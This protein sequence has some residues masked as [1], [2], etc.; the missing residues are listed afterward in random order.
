[1]TRNTP[2][3]RLAL[4]C[5]LLL[6]TLFLTIAQEDAPIVINWQP[7]ATTVTG[8]VL[9]TGTVNPEGLQSYFLEVAVYEPDS[10]DAP[11]WLPISLPSLA[12][13]IDGTLGEWNTITVPDAVYQ[14]RLHV[15][16]T[17]GDN[18]YYTIAP[19]AVA[20]QGAVEVQGQVEVIESPD[21]VVANPEVVAT[22]IADPLAMIPSP[23]PISDLPIEV[24]GHVRYFT[25]ETAA[26]MR[27]TGLTWVKWQIPF[28]DGET[29][30]TARDRINWSHEQGFNVLLSIT[31]EVDELRDLG[32][33]YYPIYADF[34]GQV[35][36]LG[37][38][39]I[40]VWNEMN[41]EREWPFGRISP[42]SYV[43]MLQQAYT[44]IKAVNPDVMVITGALAPTGAEGAF[45][46]DRVWNDDRYI[47]GMVAAG[48]ADY[49]DCIGVHYNEGILAPT[50]QGGDPRDSY[51]T[52]YLPLMLERV[53]YPFRNQ[54][55]E[56]C[57]TELGYLTPD[58]YGTLSSDFSWATGTT[59]EEHAEWLAGAIQVLADYERVPVRLMIIWN[60]DFDNYDADPQAGFA[61]LRPDG[62]CPACDTIR[63]L[64]SP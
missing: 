20:N 16:L 19:I 39:G 62:S 58:G 12:P 9:I 52:R 30:Q 64:R 22:P 48:A 29:L 63:A 42:N 7:N 1:M 56:L 4:I 57:F 15:V 33:D 53:G 50:Q 5:V 34:L 40:E 27:A 31:G 47:A 54:D 13:V 23:N 28:F 36:E 32:E 2:M 3:R 59:I 49:S 55:T 8:T 44:S 10:E 26:V 14:L 11:F 25:D 38:D 51:P 43:D 6:S 35:A 45:G 24:G 41:I 21:N 46:L 17:N 37:P 61:I 60:I 18:L